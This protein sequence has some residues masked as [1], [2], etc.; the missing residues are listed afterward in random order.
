MS[1]KATL[2]RWAALVR[3]KYLA[4]E[5]STFVLYRNVFDIFLIDGQFLDLK[6]FLTG[7]FVEDTKTTVVEVSA[8]FGVQSLKGKVTLD[9]GGD[10]LAQLHSL[11]RHLRASHGTAVIVPYADT[12]MPGED[13][14]FDPA[15]VT[16]AGAGAA[17]WPLGA[18]R[19][20]K[21]A[22]A[23]SRARSTSSRSVASRTRNSRVTLSSPASTWTTTCSPTQEMATVADRSLVSRLARAR[24]SSSAVFA[25]GRSG[26][27]TT[28]GS[29][30]S[31]AA[32]AGGIFKASDRSIPRAHEMARQPKPRWCPTR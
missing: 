4:G 24:A 13:G 23:R 6:E 31:A 21:S 30:A 5:A 25:W 22:S 7:V 29:T 12:L 11:E 3:E 8:E 10:L 28:T 26:H 16:G 19:A 20:L 32:R 18:T 15:G 2:P 17:V 1:T 27:A 14:A 9:Q